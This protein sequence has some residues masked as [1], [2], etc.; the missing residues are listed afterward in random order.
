MDTKI[1]PRDYMGR[2]WSDSLVHDP[3]C[4]NHIVNVFGTLR[5]V[6]HRRWLDASP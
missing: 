5:V 1:A 3:D 4:L 2:F 6:W